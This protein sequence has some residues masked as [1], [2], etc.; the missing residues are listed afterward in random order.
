[1]IR[2]LFKDSKKNDGVVHYLHGD[3]IVVGQDHVILSKSLNYP[4]F[5]KTTIWNIPKFNFICY[6]TLRKE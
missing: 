3:N 6:E 2:V 5:R 4:L 1:M